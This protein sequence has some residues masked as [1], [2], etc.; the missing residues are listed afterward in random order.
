MLL[1]VVLA[2]GGVWGYCVQRDRIFPWSMLRSLG[3]ST[4]NTLI[5]ESDGR[6]AVEVAREGQIVWQF[7]NPG[8]GGDR[9]QYIA[10]LPEVLRLPAGFAEG[11]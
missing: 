3:L 1:V 8:R 5:T 11:W 9:D 2:I 7:Y 4:G 6:Q 10:T